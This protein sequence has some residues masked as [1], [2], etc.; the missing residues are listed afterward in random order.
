MFCFA[1]EG[2]E[3]GVRE[4]GSSWDG[5]KVLQWARAGDERATLHLTGCSCILALH[6]ES[7]ARER[8]RSR[9]PKLPGV[10]HKL[11]TCCSGPG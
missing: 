4:R 5:A 7:V 1:F 8:T 3:E 11:A 6:E 9:W 10:E 2:H